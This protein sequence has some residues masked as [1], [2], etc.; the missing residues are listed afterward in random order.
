MLLFNGSSRLT[1]FLT[2]VLPIVGCS[3][4]LCFC[5][6]LVHTSG[7]TGLAE[8]VGGVVGGNVRSRTNGIANGIVR[9]CG[10]P[11][12]EEHSGTAV[13][14]GACW[15]TGSTEHRSPCQSRTVQGRSDVR[16]NEGSAYAQRA[17]M[18]GAVAS[19]G[20]WGGLSLNSWHPGRGGL[21]TTVPMAEVR[22]LPST[23]QPFTR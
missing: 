13:S 17:G 21:E 23:E 7:R 18:V 19:G 4:G 11:I 22:A 9:A 5:P 10:A 3:G 15:A 16:N 8:S 12:Q 14:P 2:G 6:P 1:A 20:E